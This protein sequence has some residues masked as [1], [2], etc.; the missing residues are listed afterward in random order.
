MSRRRERGL[1]SFTTSGVGGREDIAGLCVFLKEMITTTPATSD[2]RLSEMMIE[3]FCDHVGDYRR[4]SYVWKKN[5]PSDLFYGITLAAIE[6]DETRNEFQRQIGSRSLNLFMQ[7]IA[8]HKQDFRI[9]HKEAFSHLALVRN[10][11]QGSIP[12]MIDVSLYPIPAPAA[13]V[14]TGSR[15]AGTGETAEKAHSR[16]GGTG[17]APDTR[18]R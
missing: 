18:R 16:T 1:A 12:D 2:D 7:Q 11:E 15:V 10:A 3:D 9:N 17:E 13:A 6:D 5:L 8:K 14:V 4:E